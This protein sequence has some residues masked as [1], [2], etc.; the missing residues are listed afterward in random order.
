MLINQPVPI[1]PIG[2]ANNRFREQV[3]NGNPGHHRLVATQGVH[4]LGTIAVQEI[5][6]LV[7]LFPDSSFRESFEPFGDRDFVIVSYLGIKVWAKID[8]FDLNM[9]FMSE[10]PAD[11]SRTVRVLTLMLPDEY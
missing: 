7:L 9:K 8:S 1:N 10:N 11:D 3:L 2:I 5:L 4:S 6:E